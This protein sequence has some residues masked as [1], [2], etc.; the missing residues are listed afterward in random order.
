MCLEIPV[1][2]AA[3]LSEERQ[4]ADALLAVVLVGAGVGG[5]AVLARGGVG[6]GGG[7]DDGLHLGDVGGDAVALGG[8][9][10]GEVDDGEA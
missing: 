8:E 6:L 5:E 9:L 10:G 7:A 3:R 1:K 2:V 4:L